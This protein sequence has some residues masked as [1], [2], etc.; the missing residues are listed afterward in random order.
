M[1]PSDRKR[2]TNQQRQTVGNLGG[3]YVY[4]FHSQHLE[5]D[6][7][8]ELIKDLTRQLKSEDIYLTTLDQLADW[9]RLRSN[10]MLNVPVDSK[11]FEKFQ[12]IRLSL[13]K[14]GKI[15]RKKVNTARNISS[16]H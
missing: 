11:E 4:D 10:Y 6:G 3:I 7:H 14:D 13:D 1:A 12:P 5:A 9:W 2:I 16:S 15:I 8:L